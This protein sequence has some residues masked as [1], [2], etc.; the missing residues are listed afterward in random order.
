M[1]LYTAAQ[2]VSVGVEAMDIVRTPKASFATK[3]TVAEFKGEK[4]VEVYTYPMLDKDGSVIGGT[5]TCDVRCWD[6]NN[7]IFEEKY[8]AGWVNLHIKKSENIAYIEMKTDK[9]AIHIHQYTD[10]KSDYKIK[11]DKDG[12]YYYDFTAKFTTMSTNIY[13]K[14]FVDKPAALKLYV[15]KRGGEKTYV[16]L[17][18]IVDESLDISY[19]LN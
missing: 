11:Q 10:L 6:V 8:K 14:K 12:Y 18:A 13:R 3:M 19:L 16:A 5:W 4:N 2:D 15:E 17:N 7:T 1:P 9:G